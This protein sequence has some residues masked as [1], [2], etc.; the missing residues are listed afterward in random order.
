[1]ENKFSQKNNNY[2]SSLFGK[3]VDGKRKGEFYKANQTQ[4]RFFLIH[5]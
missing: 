3:P 1:M 2:S 4:G 5:V